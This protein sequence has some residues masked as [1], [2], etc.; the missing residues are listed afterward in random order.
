MTVARAPPFDLWR[1][2]AVANSSRFEALAVNDPSP[3]GPKYAEIEVR[4][5]STGLAGVTPNHFVALVYDESG[6]IALDPSERPS[7][8]Q[9][10]TELGSPL[11][12]GTHLYGHLFKVDIFD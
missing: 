5:V 2:Y 3:N 10:R 1:W 12:K 7:I 11:P 6:A 4:D 9:T 8:W